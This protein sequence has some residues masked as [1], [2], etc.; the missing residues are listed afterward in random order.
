MALN[1]V[2]C[3]SIWVSILLIGEPCFFMKHGSKVL[4]FDPDFLCLR[5][6]RLVCFFELL[7]PFLKH[8]FRSFIGTLFQKSRNEFQVYAGGSI[9]SRGA[10]LCIKQKKGLSLQ[11]GK[12]KSSI[13]NKPCVYTQDRR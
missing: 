13:N 6:S 11:C 10:K 8:M 3:N 5:C 1:Q 2:L 12:P 7:S 4:E 9:I